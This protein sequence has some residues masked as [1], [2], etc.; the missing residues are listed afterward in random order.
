MQFGKTSFGCSLNKLSL[1]YSL[2]SWT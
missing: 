2:F 1:H